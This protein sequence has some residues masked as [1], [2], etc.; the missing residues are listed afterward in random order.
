MLTCHRPALLLLAVGLFVPLSGCCKVAEKAK[1]AKREAKPQ[2]SPANGGIIEAAPAKLQTDL[3]ETEIASGPLEETAGRV[4]AKLRRNFYIVFDGSGSMLS[5]ECSG[6][7]RR[8]LAA[9]KWALNQFLS[10]IAGEDNL[11]LLVFD[12]TGLRERVPL[13]LGNR[14]AVERAVNAVRAGAGTPLGNAVRLAVKSLDRQRKA[15]LGYG[16]YHLA[17]V[18]DGK[19]NSHSSLRTA[20]DE[21]VRLGT[22]VHTIGFCVTPQNELRQASYSYRTASNPEELKSAVLSV[23][24]EAEDF[25]PLQFEEIP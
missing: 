8:K 19:A 22:T 12:K 3:G 15:Q 14:Q 23:L 4:D 1:R 21:A 10:S 16:E 7:F 5:G 11:G 13:G 18:T 25:Q 2:P 6:R 17:I 24:G 9:A 20:L